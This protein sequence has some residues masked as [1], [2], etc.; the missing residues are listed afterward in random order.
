M[1]FG[2]HE[3]PVLIESGPVQHVIVLDLFVG[4]EMKPA[5]A[6]LVHWPAVPGDGKRLDTA[7]RE[8]DQILLK[9]IDSEGVFHLEGRKLAIGAIGLD[10]EFVVFP[11]EAGMDAEIVETRVVEIA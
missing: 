3:I 6:A 7:I 10:E 5:L 2:A 8:F 9:G 4:I 11:E 1:A